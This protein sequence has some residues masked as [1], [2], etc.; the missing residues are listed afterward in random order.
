M[1]HG[2][3]LERFKAIEFFAFRDHFTHPSATHNPSSTG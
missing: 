2:K 1:A 3:T